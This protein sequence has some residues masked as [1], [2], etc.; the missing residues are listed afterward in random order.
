MAFSKEAEERKNQILDVSNRLFNEKGYDNTSVADIIREVGIAKGT[1]YY[2]FKSKEEIMDAI[3]ERT[4]SILLER[5]K[6][7]VNNDSLNVHEKL[8]RCIQALNLEENEGR[9]IMNHIHKPQNALIHQKELETM[10]E[11]VTPLVAKIIQQ[12]IDE[13]KFNTKYPY[14]AT[15]MAIIYSQIAFDNIKELTQEEAVKKIM[16]FIYNLEK[17]F[18]V[19]E[20][21]LNYLTQLFF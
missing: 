10:I 3:V 12:G 18:E 16:G 17:L 9:E 13:G 21:S 8:L 5:A 11:N 19:E 1:L 15:E 20:G 4:T 6:G 2:Y 14:E 7:V